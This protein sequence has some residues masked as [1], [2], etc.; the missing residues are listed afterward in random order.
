MKSPSSF[1][2]Q[3]AQM[4]LPSFFTDNPSIPSP[5]YL[6]LASGTVL[7]QPS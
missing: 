3:T 1:S 6:M 7:V 5:M 4:L 2:R